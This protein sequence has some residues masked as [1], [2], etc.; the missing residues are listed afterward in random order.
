MNS[1]ESLSHTVWDCKYHVV[2]IPKYRKKA[3][4]GGLRT[5]MGEII[6][7]L[8][9]QRE[10]RVVE[11]HLMPD[12][13]HMMIAIPP[14]Y[15]VS[16]VVGYIKGKSAIHIARAYMGKRKNFTGQNFWARGYFVSTVGLNE[17]MVRE[18]IKKQEKEDK[19]LEQLQ[20]FQ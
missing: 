6:R 12:H 3:L 10:C 2:W 13:V 11:G 15:S 20:L 8:A 19:R 1:K 17:E 16:S 14:K 9:R 5:H 18:Y 4:Y 7:E